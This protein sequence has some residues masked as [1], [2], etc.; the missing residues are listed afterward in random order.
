LQ[1]SKLKPGFS[2]LADRDIIKPKRKIWRKL[3]QENMICIPGMWG[4]LFWR[5]YWGSGGDPVRNWVAGAKRK[6][7]EELV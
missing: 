1:I 6:M 5:M 4:S 3:R 2:K 7:F